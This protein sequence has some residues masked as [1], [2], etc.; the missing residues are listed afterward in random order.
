MDIA[1]AGLTWLWN[2]VFQRTAGGVQVIAAADHQQSI[3]VQQS[4][5]LQIINFTQLAI[6]EKYTI[7]VLARQPRKV[8]PLDL[9]KLQEFFVFDPSVFYDLHLASWQLPSSCRAIAFSL[10]Q[11]QRD[12]AKTSESYFSEQENGS[13]FREILGFHLP[14]AVRESKRF[15][16]ALDRLRMT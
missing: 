5:V 13:F 11:A 12:R 10:L 8:Y 15:Q 1:H 6:Y 4:S 16:T 14:P 9:Y 2:R 7:F 3:H